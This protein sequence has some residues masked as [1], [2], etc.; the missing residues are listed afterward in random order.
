M[1]QV[2]HSLATSNFSQDWSNINLITTDN[3]WSGVPSILGALG[4]WSDR[5]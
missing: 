3:D 5:Y 2:Y 4:D 1:T